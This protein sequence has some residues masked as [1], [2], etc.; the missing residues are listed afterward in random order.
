MKFELRSLLTGCFLVPADRKVV[1]GSSVTKAVKG[2]ESSNAGTVH[3][4]YDDLGRASQGLTPCR[5]HS[6][7]TCL[8]APQ[9]GKIATFH[10]WHAKAKSCQVLVP[11]SFLCVVINGIMSNPV[12]ERQR[13]PSKTM[14]RSE[15]PQGIISSPRKRLQSIWNRLRSGAS[16]NIES[17]ARVGGAL[18]FWRALR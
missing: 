2:L 15:P 3:P 5:T 16:T 18:C 8:V 4:P 9:V 13:R 10:H 1:E 12:E 11:Q 17:P 7:A 14:L 6:R